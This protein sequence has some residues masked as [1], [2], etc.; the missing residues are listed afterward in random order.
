MRSFHKDILLVDFFDTIMFRK[1][2][3][4]QVYERWA[5]LLALWL[6]RPDICASLYTNRSLVIA[7]LAKKGIEEAWREIYL[8]LYDLQD[9]DIKR[10]V[11]C[12]TFVDICHHLEVNCEIGVQYPHV[13][14]LKRIH[15]FKADG[16]KVYIVSDFHLDQNDLKLFLKAK[17]ID[18]NSLF[19]GIY[20]SADYGCSKSNGLLYD[21]VLG[22]LNVEPKNVMMLGDNPISD[23]MKAEEKGIE[24]CIER[25]FIPKIKAQIKRRLGYDYA[26]H[27]FQE[28]ERICRKY[29]A[30]FIEYSLI[31]YFFARD[32]RDRVLNKN[33]R[34]VSFL[35]REGYYLK[36][37]YDEILKITPPNQLD[38][39]YIMC[40]RRSCQSADIESL[41]AL[42][43]HLISLHDYLMAYGY[44]EDQISGICER[45]HISE[46]ELFSHENILELNPAY[47]RLMKNKEFEGMLKEKGLSSKEAFREY[48]SGFDADETMN[49]VDIGG[50]GSMQEAI[51]ESL[52]KPTAGY[53]VLLQDSE[54]LKDNKEG[55]L[56]FYSTDRSKCSRFAGILRANIQLY[57]QLTAAPH[58]SPIGYV[59]SKNGKVEVLTDWAE[60]EKSLYENVIKEEQAEMDLMIRGASAW[61]ES[62]DRKDVIK[63][64]AKM[65]LRSSLLADKQ[66]LIFLKIWIKDLCGI[67]IP[68]I[69]A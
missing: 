18:F 59:F 38:S 68:K 28:I 48:L 3:P 5:Y 66:R 62:Y 2:H 50:R 21:K 54:Y 56:F 43:N 57:E 55:L 12:D 37:C 44:D 32:L 42:S 17:H 67:S 8:A 63:A 36:K 29:G 31:F 51:G 33:N 46:S 6:E 23:G 69:R 64:T 39:N 53:Y 60:N 52:S 58:G 49:I 25:N 1:V 45:F 30:P 11:S 24:A 26:N 40:S 13:N 19:D 10:K 27:S 9:D 16:G 34:H 35:S 65:V 61:C 14:L 41:K 20:V 4:Y 7:E 47:L 15:N 22:D